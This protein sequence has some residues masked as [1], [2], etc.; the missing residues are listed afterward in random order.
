MRHRTEFLVHRT[1]SR[2]ASPGSFTADS[3]AVRVSSL[4]TAMSRLGLGSCLRPDGRRPNVARRL[5]CAT[6]NKTGL[7][8]ALNGGVSALEIR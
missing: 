7:L 8:P 5:A 2:V 4:S 1:R 6:Q 3:A